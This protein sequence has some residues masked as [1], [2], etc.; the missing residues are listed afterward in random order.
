[1]DE[2]KKL[3]DYG[4]AAVTVILVI[5]KDRIKKLRSYRIPRPNRLFRDKS[6]GCVSEP[7]QCRLHCDV[8]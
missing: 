3:I 8:R 7:T 1:M 6:G 2:T 4:L 5:M